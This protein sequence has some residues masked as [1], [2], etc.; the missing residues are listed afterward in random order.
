MQIVCMQFTF[1]LM[2]RT[3]TREVGVHGEGRMSNSMWHAP[4][5]DELSMGGQMSDSKRWICMPPLVM[6]TAKPWQK[7]ALRLQLESSN[8][9]GVYGRGQGWP[10]ASKPRCHLF[11]RLYPTLG[12]SR[13]AA[14]EGRNLASVL[15]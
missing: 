12:W 9:N 1:A 14:A 2:A 3:Y 13:K 10:S 6:V 11:W 4:T 8:R 5:G 15:T 7:F